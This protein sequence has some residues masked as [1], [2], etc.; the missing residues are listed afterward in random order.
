M[1]TNASGTE[2]SSACSGGLAIAN[3]GEEMIDVM[4][5]NGGM[6]S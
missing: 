6:N 1:E 2:Y 4:A 5:R 3:M